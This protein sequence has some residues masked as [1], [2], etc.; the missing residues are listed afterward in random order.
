MKGM[1]SLVEWVVRKAWD[2]IN[3]EHKSIIQAKSIVSRAGHR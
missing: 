2:Y 1:I 3:A